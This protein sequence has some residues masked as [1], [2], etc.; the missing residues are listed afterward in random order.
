MNETGRE[1]LKEQSQ[2]MEEQPNTQ[3]EESSQETAIN[4][5]EQ[6]KQKL[7]EAEKQGA[8]YKDQLL[9]KAAEF[10]NYKRRTENDFIERVKYANE[11]LVY[12]ILPV[13]DDFERSLKNTKEK[14]DF[15][16][17]HRGIELISQKM[18]KILENNGVVAYVSAGKPFDPHLH[19]ALMQL[20]KPDVPPHTVIEEVEK[21]YM[22]HGKVLRH[23]K[24]I[25]STEAPE[26]K[27]NAFLE[28][29]S[30]VQGQS[31]ENGV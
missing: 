24:V 8:Q 3:G 9:R 22:M 18:N 26:E 4:E 28:E 23:A 29:S 15:D 21:G 20:P 14:S 1:E 27:E 7:V 11:E 16:T 2:A 5:T 17:L 30:P 13:L 12:E 19:D 6:L 10:E 31:Q 25:V